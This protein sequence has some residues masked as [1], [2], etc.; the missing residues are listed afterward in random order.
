MD[1]P[2]EGNISRDTPQIKYI[3]WEARSP[4]FGTYIAISR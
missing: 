2:N 1:N 4:G 3:P